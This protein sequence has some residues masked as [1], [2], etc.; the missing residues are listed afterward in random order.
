MLKR[1]TMATIVAFLVTALGHYFIYVRL[2]AP[3]VSENNEIFYRSL[4][5]FLWGLTF[6]GFPIT[7]AVP[8]SLRRFVE[9]PMFLWM[10][11]AY[12]ACLVGIL[13]TPF[14]LSIAFAENVEAH[15]LL[16]YVVLAVSGIVTIFAV[17]QAAKKETIVESIIPFNKPLPRE[18]EALKIVVLSDI[19][20]SGLIGWRRMTRLKNTVNELEPDLIF[21]TGD[22]VDGSVRQLKSEVAPLKDLKSKYGVYYI[23]GNHEYYCNA[24]QW[25]KHISKHL[26]WHVLSNSSETIEIGNSKINIIGI[27]D[28]HWLHALRKQGI[29][30]DKRLEMATE[31]IRSANLQS[32]PTILLAH[33]PKDA[34]L[35][36]A[37]PWIDLQISGHTH[38]GQFWPLK[39]FVKR[40]Q[41]FNVGLYKLS[42][43]QSIY[44]NQGTGFWGPPMRL[45]TQCEI[46]V[47]TPRSNV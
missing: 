20:I 12:I 5:T 8:V 3:I 2:V 46:S 40:D 23:T 22:L 32:L 27:E 16:A 38:G 28:R 47:L 43:T 42:G 34:A 44:V 14:S 13:T 18:L 41:I 6:F 7:R 33:Q 24:E 4:I 11:T 45:G 26:N 9:V 39:I 29:T 1:L 37:Y 19:H 31:R 15:H 25:K 30:E 17:F 21:V 10:G 35:T 36:T